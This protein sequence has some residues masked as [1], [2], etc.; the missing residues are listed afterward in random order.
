[1]EKQKTYKGKPIKIV[2]DFSMETLKARRAWREVFQTLNEDNFN[3]RLLHQAKLSLKIDG[4]I[5]VFHDKQKQTI[6]GHEVT[7]TKDSPRNSAH[8]K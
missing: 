2:A 8:R 6:Y 3:R 4:A 1:V 7:T 5:K